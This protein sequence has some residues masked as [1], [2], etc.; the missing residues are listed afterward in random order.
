MR[1]GA[2]VREARERAG[3]T[4]AQLAAR[5]GTTQSAIARLENGAEPSLPRLSDLLGACGLEMR[6]RLVGVGGDRA[7]AEATTSPSLDAV[8]ELGRAGVP[9]VLAGRAAAALHGVPV[10]IHAPLVVPELSADALS[11][12]AGSLESLRARRRVDEEGST[13]PFDRSPSG[14]RT[15]T[16]WALAT[17]RGSVDIDFEPDGTRGFVDL[18]RRAVDDEGILVA[19]AADTA[20]QLDAAGDDLAVVTRLRNLSG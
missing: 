18:A 7:P 16:R 4:Q 5:A 8:R 11:S 10:A 12:L 9:F 17:E 19:A 20:R 1:G 6:I 2:L 14:L 13:L 3:L 15:R